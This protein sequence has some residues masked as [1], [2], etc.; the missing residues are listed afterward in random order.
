M[1]MCGHRH[2]QTKHLLHISHIYTTHTPHKHTPAQV[3]QSSI[4]KYCA[5]FK[6]P[7]GSYK[8]I[9]YKQLSSNQISQNTVLRLNPTN[10]IQQHAY[11][12]QQKTRITH[13]DDLLVQSINVTFLVQQILDL[14]ELFRAGHPWGNNGAAPVRGYLPCECRGG[15]PAWTRSIGQYIF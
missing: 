10:Q 14:G 4:S 13:R 3:S 6:P 5:K 1:W 15:R 7:I 2:K 11:A 8:V 12:S 9:I